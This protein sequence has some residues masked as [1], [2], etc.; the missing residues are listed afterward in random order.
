MPLPRPRRP[1]LLAAA[2]SLLSAAAAGAAERFPRPEFESGYVYPQNLHP[3]PRAPGLEWLD[4]GVLL[5][6]LGLASWLALRARSRAGLFA[7]MLGCLAYFGFYRDGCVCAVGSPQN[8][9]L[10]L[11]DPTY[12]I[13][14]TV[15]GFFLLPLLFA[16]ACGRVFC[17]A[18]CPLGAMQDAVILYPV[19]LPRWLAGVLGILPAA[20]LGTAVLLAATGAGFLICRYDPFV[21]FF[22]LGAPAA[23]LLAGAGVLLLGVF[24]ARPYCRFLCPYAVLLRWLSPLARRRTTVTPEECVQCRLC[25]DACPVDAIRPP[26]GRRSPEDAA[27]R[28]RRAVGLALLWPALVLGGA[29]GAQ[30]LLA[31]P[32]ARLHPTVATAEQ[33]LAEEEGRFETTTLRS[34]AFRAGGRSRAD[35]YAAALAVRADL[36]AGSWWLGAFLGLVIGGRLLAACVYRTRTDYAPDP[37][38]CVSCGRCYEYC[39]VGRGP[40]DEDDDDDAET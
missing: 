18:V 16:L 14:G 2:A 5:L 35:L 34:E 25:E 11:A 10:A 33:V 19:R 36:R 39:P 22:R 3:A 6:A 17:A 38:E 30:G 37:A 32:L 29:Y 7:L 1:A 24:V 31:G 13:P 26:T 28:R 12:L 8:V 27:R 23:M 4:V 40:A 21:G 9:A 20:Y 15:V